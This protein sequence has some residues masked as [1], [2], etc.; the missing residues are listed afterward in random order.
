[1]DWT[2]IDD[3]AVRHKWQC[4]EEDCDG[5]ATVYPEWYEDNGTPVCP[6]CDR[7]M[8]YVKTEIEVNNAI[9][10]MLLLD[11]QAQAIGEILI[12]NLN[13]KVTDGYVRTNSGLKTPAGLARTIG[14]LIEEVVEEI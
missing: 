5:E 1:M 6:D 10:S 2:K 8:S 7:D 9:A 4:L 13:L 14:Q 12:D 11:E 3:R